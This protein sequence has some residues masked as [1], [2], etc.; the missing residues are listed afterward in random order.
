M[1]IA[2]RAR[3]AVGIGTLAFLPVMLKAWRGADISNV[4]WYAEWHSVLILP[5]VL[6]GLAV[7]AALVFG[8]LVSKSR[9]LLRIWTPTGTAPKVLFTV[10]LCGVILLSAAPDD[11]PP[12]IDWVRLL[13]IPCWF[14]V[15]L[16]IAGWHER[17]LNTGVEQ[18]LPP[19]SRP[20]E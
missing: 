1:K 8:W 6:S 10:G 7:F 11:L 2:T 19:Q 17:I 13:F 14:A 4:A 20:L 12:S 3:I 16:S 18:K 9:Y 15:T 5:L